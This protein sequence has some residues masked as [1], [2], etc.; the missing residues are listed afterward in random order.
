MKTAAWNELSDEQRAEI[1]AR[2]HARG[3]LCVLD[4]PAVAVVAAVR[5]AEG[6]VITT[7]EGYRVSNYAQSGS[8]YGDQYIWVRERTFDAAMKLVAERLIEHKSIF[9]IEYDERDHD[10]KAHA[11]AFVEELIKNGLVRF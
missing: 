1:L 8:D 10:D 5:A 2:A 9:V 3:H 7:C 11:K 4:E 6:L